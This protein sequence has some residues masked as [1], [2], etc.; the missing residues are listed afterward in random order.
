MKLTVLRRVLHRFSA[1]EKGLLAAII[2][3]GIA[4]SLLSP[5][6]LTAVNLLN[7]SRQ[8]ALVGI[9]G[10]G[11][12]YC[13][14]GG[15]F[16][17]SVGST[18]GLV[19]M[20]SALTVIGG[21]GPILGII[22]GLV[23]GMAVGVVNGVLTTRVNI[24]SFIVTLGTLL[25]GRGIVLAVTAGYPVPLYGRG[26]PQWFLYYHIFFFNLSNAKSGQKMFLIPVL[27]Q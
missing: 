17:L 2:V 10:V 8:M 20:V 6:F 4:L 15:E 16:D 12:A 14:I 9:L 25:I 11:M 18:L 21:G 7:V 27:T 22:V 1:T 24:P 26:V 13:I 23:T 19:A 5:V 3:A